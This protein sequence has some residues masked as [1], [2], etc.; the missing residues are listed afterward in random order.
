MKPNVNPWSVAMF[1]PLLVGFALIVLYGLTT[2]P[3]GT[4]DYAPYGWAYPLG[5]VC[6]LGSAAIAVFYMLVD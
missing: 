4:Y 5:V 6:I 3:L 2:V 1:V